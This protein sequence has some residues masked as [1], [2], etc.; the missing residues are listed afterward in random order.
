MKLITCNREHRTAKN[1]V[2]LLNVSV[3]YAI[4]PDYGLQSVED[5]QQLEQVFL[6]SLQLYP[7]CLQQFL[8]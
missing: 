7:F 5:H 6:Q 4:Y 2:V 8:F 3:L 1:R